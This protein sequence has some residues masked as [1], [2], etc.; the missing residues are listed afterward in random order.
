MYQ[1]RFADGFKSGYMAH[2]TLR[3]LFFA[4][5]AQTSPEPLALEVERAEGCWMYQ[6]DGSRVL[7][8]ISGISVSNLGHRHPAVMEAIHRQLDK[9]LHLMVY[10]ELVQTPQ[11]LLAQA[12][13]E[14]TGGYLS[15]AY[16]VNS[17]SE[18]IEGAL[19][20]AK[21]YTGRY[22]IV[23]CR[24]AYHG[25]SHGALS[26]GGGEGFKGGYLP[27]VPGFMH[28]RHG[29]V[30]DLSH[31]TRETAAVLI[32]PIQ[33]EA[34]VREASL[35]YWQALRTRCDETGTLLI[36]DEI[37]TG[38]GRTGTFWH[39]EQLGI[40]P[41]ILV[42]AKGMGGGMPIGAFLAS[43]GVMGVLKENPVLG[44]ITTFGGH[45]VSCAASLAT[46]ETLRS[47]DLL[48]QVPAKAARFAAGLQGLGE[49]R[50]RGMLMAL[51]M[52]SFDR[53][54]RVLK[55]LLWEEGVL[56][57]WF[58]YCDT[59]IRLAPP[60]TITEAEIDYATERIRRSV[61]ATE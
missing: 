3:S 41:D 16:F 40:R 46:L 35:A 57:D 7:D 42:T 27:L 19:K 47:A 49:L 44:H 11:V 31:I 29:V 12:L 20:L 54:L 9:Y 34:G 55:K 8:L 22:R 51:E 52:G 18:A 2:S 36:L 61:I 43:E 45:P 56:S 48:G 4:H 13:S 1:R 24:Q 6:P 15:Q 32:E 58:L 50:Q 21:R 30:E 17:G 28:I 37:Q 14:T 25:S 33:G 5:Q 53:V 38:F 23:S 26:A 60:L 10:G 59:A 39:Y